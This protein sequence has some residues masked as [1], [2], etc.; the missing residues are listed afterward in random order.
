[1]D[2]GALTATLGVNSDGLRK[3][4]G[5]LRSFASTADNQFSSVIRKA[6]VLAT[7]FLTVSV[8]I[9]AVSDAVSVGM[10]M[11]TL[12]SVTNTIAKNMGFS[13]D[14]VKYFVQE[15]KSAGVTT[16]E[17]MAG[18]GKA[19]ALGLDL[20]RMKEF[21]TRV[22]DVAVGARD[23]AGNILNTSETFTKSMLGIASGNVE[24]FRTIGI[25]AFRDS[26][27][28]L[29]AYG[30]SIGLAGNELVNLKSKL[31]QAQISTAMLNEYM[32]ASVPLAGAAASAD[33]T[34]G[35][36]LA[37]MARYS[38]DAKVALWDLFKPGM[39]AGVV[40]MSTAFR[41][42]EKWAKANNTSLVQTGIQI[43]NF[44]GQVSAVILNT[45]KWIA[46]NFELIKSF[47]EFYIIFKATRWVIGLA[48]SLETLYIAL[49]AAKVAQA[50]QTIVVAEAVVKTIWLAN[51][52]G[53]VTG[54]AYVATP[55][56]TTAGGAAAS[57]GAMAAGA[58]AGWAALGV[59][60]GIAASAFLVYKTFDKPDMSVEAGPGSANAL[61]GRGYGPAPEPA[62]RGPL[63]TPDFVQAQRMQQFQQKYAEEATAN[64]IKKMQEQMNKGGGAGGGAG[65]SAEA[66]E[67]SLKSFISTMESETARGAGDSEAILNTW[68]SKQSQT[69]DKLAA[70]NIDITKGK[71]ALDDAYYSK[72][73]KLNSDFSDWY[74]SG[75]GNQYEALV[76]AEGKK[77]SEVAGNAEKSA[78]VQEVFTRKHYDLEQQMESDRL[79]L[80]KGYLDSMSSLSPILAD[81]LG[82]KKDALELELRQAEIA[83]ERQR[84]EGKITQDTYDQAMAMQALVAQAKKFNLEM[85]HNKG[86]EGWAFA[87]VKAESQKNTWADAMEG[88]EGFV[89]DA[90]TQGAQGALGKVKIDVI[91][92]GKTFAL[93]AALSL[94]KQGI[95]KLFTLGAEAIVGGAGKPDGSAARPFH[96]ISAPG[97]GKSI[98][99]APAPD[100]A[101]RAGKIGYT[102]GA[103]GGDQGWEDESRSLKTYEKMLDKM[104]KGQ[105]KD[106]GGVQRL[107]ERFLKD[108]LRDLNAYGQMQDELI[109]GNQEL[110]R[111]EYLTDYQGSF[112]NMTTGITGLWG[113]AQGLMTAAG[114]SGDSQ[115]IASLAGYAMQA[116]GIIMNLAKSN[117]LAKASEGAAAAY[118]SAMA[119][120][121]F[122]IN[123]IVAPLYAAGTFI[124]ITAFGAMGGYSGGGGSGISGQSNA[125]NMQAA[126]PYHSGG[127]LRPVYAHAGFPPL[128]P[129]EVPFI[130][131]D[132]ERVL[133]PR[134]TYD[135]EAGMREGAMG[136]KPGGNGG[137]S[138]VVYSP[139]Y[140]IQAID[141]RGVEAV[142]AKHGKAMV[143]IINKSGGVGTRGQKLGSWRY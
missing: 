66:A 84:T 11:E 54:A 112:A 63:A 8:A 2:I 75:L 111:A 20:N 18:V 76:A 128:K 15:V 92:L 119:G 80:F 59:A 42:L 117:I 45:V 90:W 142:L 127:H 39:E 134:Q 98:G 33:E 36:Q 35:K 105:L 38:E 94:G 47:A 89:N 83:L 93:S 110:F 106:M 124:A 104:Y 10:K 6:A 30:K 74:I 56:I 28:V 96:V 138:P 136:A 12:A 91:E 46:V 64:H 7:S 79:G 102:M 78:K 82:Y 126:V 120:L 131:L 5:D 116:I 72:L 130:G 103:G 16:T 141:A 97:I 4:E 135:Y 86:L 67:S 60:I 55:A 143:R 70:K 68:Y 58:V 23:A 71:E 31:N 113:T 32:R 123:S 73:D 87:R 114:V 17:A 88:L 65:K 107:Q 99:S 139:T 25:V 137:R 101:K 13:A 26:E 27:V 22:R 24:H 53:A 52:Y 115:R 48:A 109:Q 129:G 37:S 49:T 14:A 44:I 40:A 19:M 100:F 133:S 77:L 9:K 108:D 118:A 125:T 121:P 122:P 62:K 69:L 50:A 140:H 81:Q 34:V 95:H 41:D 43:G 21:T 29:K 57:S 132:T 1:M 61:S 51:A 3:A 85:E